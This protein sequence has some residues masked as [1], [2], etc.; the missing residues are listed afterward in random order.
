MS[1]DVNKET[2]STRDNETLKEL[3]KSKNYLMFYA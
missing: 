3:C 2:F 1:A